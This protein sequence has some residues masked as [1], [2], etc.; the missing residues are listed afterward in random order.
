MSTL[1]NNAYA[2]TSTNE[3]S[4]I[5]GILPA[6]ITP[7][8]QDGNVKVDVAQPLVDWYVRE[9]AAGLY[10]LGWTG[11][12]AYISVP[13]RKTWTE[14]VLKAARGRVEVWVHV[15]YSSNLQDGVELAEHAGRHGADAVSSV[16]ISQ[17]A[18]LAQN[19]AYVRT[20][21]GLCDR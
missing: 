17:D 20:H 11:E 19:V 18:G 8:D 7:F 5:Q 3:H 14:A 4:L 15:G 1:D 13:K 21:G 12:G 10:L 16:G 6:L 2:L 9:G